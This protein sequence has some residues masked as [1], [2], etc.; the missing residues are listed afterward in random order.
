MDGAALTEAVI[1]LAFFLVVFGCQ[2]FVHLL[3]AEKLRTSRRV[4]EQAWT[5]AMRACPGGATASATIDSSVSPETQRLFESIV[6]IE[7]L[8]QAIGSTRHQRTALVTAGRSLFG[9][10]AE[11]ESSSLVTCNERLVDLDPHSAAELAWHA[12]TGW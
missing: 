10:R 5:E 11:L 4:R 3:H 12:L 2:S 8:E 6:G 9:L 7:L 1:V